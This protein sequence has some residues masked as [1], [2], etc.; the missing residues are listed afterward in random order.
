LRV[1]HVGS[2]DVGGGAARAANRLHE[3]LR[4]LGHE[5]VM[6]V[7]ERESE[8]PAVR[9]FRPSASV[10]DR[11]GRM[12]RRRRIAADLAPFL[13]T[14]PA[15]YEQ[16]SDDRT[17]WAGEVAGQLPACDLVHLH[18]VA[19]FVDHRAFLG[20]LPPGLPVV[21]TLHD[22]NAFTGGCHYDDG[23]GRFVASCGACPQLGSTDPTDL[24]HA[25]WTRK[26]EALRALGD[27]PVRIVADSRWM[28]GEARRSSLLGPLPVSTI[29][30][31]LD[32]E[33]FAPRPRAEARAALGVPADARVVL[34]VADAVDQR[35]KGFAFLVEALAGLDP[36]IPAFL[37][38]IG[39]GAPR[40]PGSLPALHLG[41]VANDRLLSVVYSAAD[42]FV[43]P[44][45]QE[46]FGQTA[47][48]AMACGTPV[49]GFDTGGIPDIVRP[50]VTGALAR[51]GDAGSLREAIQA[52]LQDREEWAR[53]AER[54]RHHVLQHHTLE[55]QA[56]RYLALYEEVL[57]TLP[58][59][60]AAA[61][62]GPPSGAGM[63]VP[64]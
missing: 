53:T 1:V 64:R 29:H 52:M 22:M 49:V 6:Y 20:S 34:F 55:A 11:L 43:I 4:R 58:G 12:L 62:P 23:C 13:A 25:V 38:S 3:G 5:S 21:W 7:L 54:C 39:R 51:C 26:A 36:A 48:E 18:W 15:G 28:E 59:A 41:S 32:T 2:W 16:F 42:L 8:D 61:R 47:L 27:R 9:D 63:S 10:S 60:T 35:R 31:G 50:G 19:G 30:Y 37:L 45:L 57:G 56:R 40:L 14:R 24:S 17:L 33:V 44:S 46:A